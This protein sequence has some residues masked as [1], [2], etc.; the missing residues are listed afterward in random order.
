VV[1]DPLQDRDPAAAGDEVGDGREGQAFRR[2][3]RP[4]VDVETGHRLH[5]PVLGYVDRSRLVLERRCELGVPGGGEQKRSD[6][7]RGAQ[8]LTDDEDAFGD[9]YAPSA[10]DLDAAP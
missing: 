6:R 4:P 5:D 10:F 7:I 3:H 9:E 8:Q 2:G 1:V